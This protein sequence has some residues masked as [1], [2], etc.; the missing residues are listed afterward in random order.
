MAGS[1]VIT[2]HGCRGI[3]VHDIGG[4]WAD[5]CGQRLA[6]SEP[7]RMG[8]PRGYF[9]R[10]CGDRIAR[11][12]LAGRGEGRVPSSRWDGH[13]RLHRGPGAGSRGRL[14]GVRSAVGR[15][16]VLAEVA[17]VVGNP[18]ARLSGG[19]AHRIAVP[20]CAPS[21]WGRRP[22]S[23]PFAVAQPNR[24]VAHAV[25]D[26]T[27]LARLRLR[28]LA[29]PRLHR[30]RVESA[31]GRVAVRREFGDVGRGGARVPDAQ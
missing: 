12:R 10:G 28:R 4:P 27:S 25:L 18:C 6:G 11:H 19:V 29:P 20:A 3:S 30:A 24:M 15:V 14:C 5:H 22:A 8:A 7:V 9:R 31:G 1:S 26:R 23:A 2:S 13:G 17:R 21:R 16:R